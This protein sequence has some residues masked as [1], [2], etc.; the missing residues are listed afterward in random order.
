MHR[1]LYE[2][3]LSLFVCRTVSLEYSDVHACLLAFGR[4]L[5]RGIILMTDLTY[6]CVHVCITKKIGTT[7]TSIHICANPIHL[8]MLVIQ[9]LPGCI[10][11]SKHTKHLVKF[12]YHTHTHIYIYVIGTY[13]V[14]C[15]ETQYKRLC[16]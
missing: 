3:Y 15:L 11:A 10:C 2:A 1:Y 4:K 16:S 6:A 8:I 13:M 5:K 7:R 14:Y 12:D 9:P